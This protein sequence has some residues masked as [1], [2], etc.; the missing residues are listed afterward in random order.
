MACFTLSSCSEDVLGS[1]VTEAAAFSSG[2]SGAS[3]HFSLPSKVYLCIYV[4]FVLRTDALG[5]PGSSR[6]SH[7]AE[8]EFSS[9]A[10]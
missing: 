10:A 9:D 5:K 1:S 3:F 8:V 2:V 4:H 6:I 7:K